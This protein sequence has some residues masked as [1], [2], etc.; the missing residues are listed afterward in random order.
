MLKLSRWEGDVLVTDVTPTDPARRSKMARMTMCARAC[1]TIARARLGRRPDAR[2]RCSG[3][4]IVCCRAPPRAVR[5]RR[6]LLGSGADAKLVLE[7]TYG[8]IVCTR[9]FSRA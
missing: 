9:E 1:H 6:Y 4:Y 5:R 7:M 2:A 3:A 8:D